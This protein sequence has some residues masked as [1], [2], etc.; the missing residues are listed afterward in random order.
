MVGPLSVK[1]E[2]QVQR[3]ETPKLRGGCGLPEVT[4]RCGS[5]LTLGLWNWI[6]PS[7]HCDMGM[8]QAGGWWGGDTP[9]EA[10]KGQA[11]QAKPLNPPHHRTRTKFLGLPFNHLCLSFLI[12]E[13]STMIEQQERLNKRMYVQS[14]ANGEN[15]KYPQIT[16]ISLLPISSWRKLGILQRILLCG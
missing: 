9:R 11:C 14:S 15:R 16:N 3:M 2:A 6:S 8:S 7:A 1:Q 5:N 13:M 10:Q 4:Q 12:F